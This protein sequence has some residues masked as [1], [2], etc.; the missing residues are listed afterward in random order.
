MD[1]TIAPSQDLVSG[2]EYNDDNRISYLA[3]VTGR[4]RY[5][6]ACLLEEEGRLRADIERQIQLHLE[7]R[8]Y[9]GLPYGSP[10][11]RPL[12]LAWDREM[13]RLNRA[14][15]AAIGATWGGKAPQKLDSTA[16]RRAAA[17]LA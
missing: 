5:E 12:R 3:K 4:T 7:C 1:A 15:S 2:E 6:V 16:R 11:R 13:K 9:R 10:L 14:R 17:T 8:P